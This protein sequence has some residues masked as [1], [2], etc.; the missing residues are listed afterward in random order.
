MTRH[1]PGHRSPRARGRRGGLVRRLATVAVA[2]AGAV[3]ADAAVSYNV[4]SFTKSIAAATA[5]QNVAHGL[6][7]VPKAVVLWTDGKTS[8]TLGSDYRFAFGVTDGTTDKSV[9]ASSGNGLS[10]TSANRRV[11]SKALTIIDSAGT[12]LA[13]ADLQSFDATN[14]TLG[15]TT[16]NGSAYVIHFLA[17]GGPKAAAKALGWTMPTSTGNHGVTGVG[18]RPDVVITAH[19]GSGLTT[20][21]PSTAAHAGFGLSAFDAAGDAWANAV[22]STDGVSTSDASRY[23]RTDQALVSVGGSQSKSKE[24]SWVS[25]DTDGFTLDWTTANSSAGQAISLALRG[26]QAS[27]GSLAKTTAAATASQAVT[28][29]PFKPVAVLLATVQA[30]AS[31]SV[32]AHARYGIGAGTASTDGA[33][34][35]QDTDAISPTSVDGVDRTTKGIV[36]VN[37][38]TPSVDAEADMASLDTAGFTLSWT[39]N[40]AVATEVCY[41]ALGAARR[42]MVVSRDAPTRRVSRRVPRPIASRPPRP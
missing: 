37:N 6:G 7:Q 5:T 33:S 28:G 2:V 1:D 40:D 10:T 38:N 32:A 34:A 29:V 20:G 31:T 22:F 19:A 9:A 24:A 17:V 14:F 25:M 30:T 11:A 36:K 41:L 21:P 18:F 42:V 13:E 3:P 4:G 27:V 16:N 35:F 23:Q 39:T 15:W 12:L 26:V 8:S